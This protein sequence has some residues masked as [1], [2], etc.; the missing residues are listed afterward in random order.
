MDKQTLLD[1]ISKK[2]QQI[3]KLNK[4]IKKLENQCTEEEISIAD[5]FRDNY[6]KFAAYC[7][8]YN[9]GTSFTPMSELRNAY[10]DLDE[11]TTTLNKYKNQ[12]NIIIDKESTEKVEIFVEFLNRYK[13]EVI[14]YVEKNIDLVTEYYRLN[15]E[16]CEFY[17]NRNFIIR[18][19]EMTEDEWKT[20]LKR[21]K[22]K[23]EDLQDSINPLLF[24]VYD[25][26]QDNK[27]NYEKLNEILD[28]EI[29]AKYWNMV[30]RV[31]KVT[32][33]I[34]DASDLS[35]GGDGNI[36]GIIIGKEGKAKLE[37]ILA[38][39]YNQ[40]IIVNTRRGQVLHY[41]LIVNKIK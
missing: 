29:E 36:N 15:N 6:S 2:E 9:L 25:N 37:T 12:L 19:G 7:K 22:I 24:E 4:K 27:I 32:G 26:R 39:G 1:R 13:T 8:Q 17:N 35:I 33:E 14:K 23:E 18:S 20:E 41:R 16:Y 38:G 5:S 31:T 3:E 11:A 34:I 40:N 21:K 10:S 30:E 28:K